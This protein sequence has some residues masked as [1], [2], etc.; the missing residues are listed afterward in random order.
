MSSRFASATV[1]GSVAALTVLGFGMAGSAAARV[2]DGTVLAAAPAAI[3]PL[4][5]P[6]DRPTKPCSKDNEGQQIREPGSFGVPAGF[7]TCEHRGYPPENARYDWYK[8]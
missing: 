1:I 7:W 5:H 4:L 6:A 8:Y 3:V 2:P